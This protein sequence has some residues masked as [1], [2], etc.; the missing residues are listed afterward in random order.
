MPD[1]LQREFHTAQNITAYHLNSDIQSARRFHCLPQNLNFAGF[2]L[3]RVRCGLMERFEQLNRGELVHGAVMYFKIEGET[4]LGQILQMI[5]PLYD[6]QLPK[7]STNIQWPR[8]QTGNLDT[9]LAPVSWFWHCQ[10]SNVVLKIEAVVFN[11]IGI[12][13]VSRN[14]LQFLLEYRG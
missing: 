9:K 6:V 7:G 4:A 14:S 8:V 2:V 5:Q 12:I 3:A 10:V 1:R 11:P 13:K